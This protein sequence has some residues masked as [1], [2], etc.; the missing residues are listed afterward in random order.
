MG[1]LNVIDVG[2]VR[3]PLLRSRVRERVLAKGFVLAWRMQSVHVSVEEWSCVEGVRTV[4]RWVA[5]CRGWARRS[6]D[7]QLTGCNVSWC[8]L[9]A[10]EELEEEVAHDHVRVLWKLVS[11]WA[12]KTSFTMSFENQFHHKP[13]FAHCFNCCSTRTQRFSQNWVTFC[14]C[15]ILCIFMKTYIPCSCKPCMPTVTAHL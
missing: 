13:W 11:P 7:R 15:S 3:I 14:V 4:R 6:C 8:W 1:G 10:S 9:V 12:L 5:R 2:K